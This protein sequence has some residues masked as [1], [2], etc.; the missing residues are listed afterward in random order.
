[1]THSASIDDNGTKWIGDNEGNHQ[2]DDHPELQIPNGQ[3]DDHKFSPARQ[4]IVNA[5]GRIHR[6]RLEENLRLCP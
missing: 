6:G 1:M 4:Y 2:A 5:R 3:S